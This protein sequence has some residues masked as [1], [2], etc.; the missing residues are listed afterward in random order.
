MLA[1]LLIVL[2]FLVSVKQRRGLKMQPLRMINSQAN[3][4][5]H[6]Y[7]KYTEFLQ[8]IPLYSGHTATVR[9][10][11]VSFSSVVLA[12]LLWEK[13]IKMKQNML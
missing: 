10:I 2:A 7:R 13:T 11:L 4:S 12:I 1:L 3:D 9:F 6:A 8:R 5:Y